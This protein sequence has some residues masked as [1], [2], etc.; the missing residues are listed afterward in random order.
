[1]ILVTNVGISANLAHL[2]V[3]KLEPVFLGIIPYNLSMLVLGYPLSC[4]AYPKRCPK[5]AKR[6]ITQDHYW[7]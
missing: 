5:S 2:S 7:L 6:S 4:K 1:M 3:E